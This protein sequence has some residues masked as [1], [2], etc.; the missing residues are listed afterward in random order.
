MLYNKVTKKEAKTEDV[1]VAIEPQ[2]PRSAVS[3]MYLESQ[4]PVVPPPPSAI[5]QTGSGTVT[6]V[7]ATTILLVSTGVNTVNLGTG[8]AAYQKLVIIY[9]SEA[10]PADIINLVPAS[11]LGWTSAQFFGLGD[12]LELIWTGAQWATVAGTALVV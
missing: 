1:I 5:T 2:S 6:N 10:A 11:A 3:K 7:S 4:L 9:I 12:S 8:T